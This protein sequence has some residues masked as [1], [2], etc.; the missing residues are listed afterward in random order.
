MGNVCVYIY[1]SLKHT[2]IDKTNIITKQQI[3]KQTV[4]INIIKMKTSKKNQ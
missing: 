3:K 1:V 2:K 4:N